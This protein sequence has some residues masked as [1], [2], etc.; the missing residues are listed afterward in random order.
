MWY[1]L[2]LTMANV[3]QNQVQKQIRQLRVISD[4]DML[5]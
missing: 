3:N 2:P 4:E 5:A 1:L